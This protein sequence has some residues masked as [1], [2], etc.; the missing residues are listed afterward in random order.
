MLTTVGHG[1]LHGAFNR[2]DDD[3]SRRL[4]LKYQTSAANI[5]A[6]LQGVAFD[7]YNWN[8]SYTHGETRTRLTTLNNVNAQRLYA[9]VDAVRDPQTGNIVCRVT[10]T[11]PGAY[12]G[13]LPL[14]LFGAHAPSQAALDYVEGSTAWTAH[15]GL[16]DF[17]ANITGRLFDGWA[18]PVKAAAGL[19]YQS[20]NLSLTTTAPDSNFNAQYLRVGGA[21]GASMPVGNLKW[22]KETQSAAQGDGSVYE[23]DIELNVPLLRGLPGIELL[24]FDGAYRH[25]HYSTAG[26]A[27]TWK[28]ALDWQVIDDV[29]LRGSFSRDIRAPTLFDLFQGPLTS[30]SGISDS[31]TNT[32][33][34]VN[35]TQAGN[36]GLKPE[37]AHNATAGFVYS[38]SWWNDFSLSVDYFHI[39][40]DNAIGSLNAAIRVIL[41]LCI[42]SAAQCGRFCNL[43]ARPHCDNDTFTGQFSASSFLW[44]LV[45]LSPVLQPSVALNCRRIINRA[46][47][48]PRSV[49]DRCVATGS[50]SDENQPVRHD[51]I[52]PGTLIASAAGPRGRPVHH[53]P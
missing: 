45:V 32:S 11:A 34:S 29:R 1:L 33:G 40:T 8:A 7:H 43:I 26:P 48:P 10:V 52:L 50:C 44:L 38:P 49:P 27:N 31:L 28:L 53:R 16:D 37:V 14:D 2:F 22:M 6:G 12:P 36:P 24:S 17:T 30:S 18:G 42:T 46:P 47:V 20:Q 23:G 41:R 39:A 9:A 4:G 5:S 19:E 15:N 13:C 25:T 51:Q 35:T 3:L 21:N